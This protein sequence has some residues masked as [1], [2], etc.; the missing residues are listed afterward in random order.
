MHWTGSAATPAAQANAGVSWRP[1]LAI[2]GLTCPDSRDGRQQVS[3]KGRDITRKVSRVLCTPRRPSQVQRSL[4]Y[5]LVR[6][7][8]AVLSH[9]GPNG[10][11]QIFELAEQFL[12]GF[13]LVEGASF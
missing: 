8:D 2:P 7:N 1:F 10:A 9:K 3:A 11:S 13:G 6:A 12:A 4:W 5:A